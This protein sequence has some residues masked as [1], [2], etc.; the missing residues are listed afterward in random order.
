M[1]ALRAPLAPAVRVIDRVHGDA[2]DVRPPPEPAR[3]PR[4][5][6]RQVLVLEVAHLPHGGTADQ[7]H[8]PQLR[9]RQLEQRVVAFLCHQLDRR[10]GTSSELRAAPGPQLDRADGGAEGE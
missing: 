2:T 3:A 8:A 6:V 7:T 10:A 4:L 9:G 1:V 5:A